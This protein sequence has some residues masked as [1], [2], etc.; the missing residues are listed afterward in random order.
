MLGLALP[1]AGPARHGVRL[2]PQGAADD[3]VLDNIYNLALD[4][5]RKRQFNKAENAFKYIAEN[6]P[7]FRTSPIASAAPKRC[8]RR[9]SWAAAAR[10]PAAP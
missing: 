3:A 2:V 1:G 4:Y 10:I 8:P 7:K 9:S 6:N 5:E